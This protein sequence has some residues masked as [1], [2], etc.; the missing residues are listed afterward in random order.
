MND[1]LEA[2]ES[3]NAHDFSYLSQLGGYF[4]VIDSSGKVE[5]I[6][7]SLVQNLQLEQ[8][9]WVGQD[10]FSLVSVRNKPK[11]RKAL[12]LVNGSAASIDMLSF[13]NGAKRYF[14][15]TLARNR[16]G[17]GDLNYIINLHDITKR[18][19]HEK[20][21]TLK[22]KEL[23]SF[24]YKVSHDLK[25]P[26]KSI[27]GLINLS[28]VN[29]CNKDEYLRLINHGISQ[30]QSYIT[31]LGLDVREKN[32]KISQVDLRKFLDELIQELKFTPEAHRITFNIKVRN[33]IPISTDLFLLSTILRN[34]LSNAIKYQDQDRKRP[35]VNID[36][37]T[38]AGLFCVEIQDNGIGISEDQ[39]RNIFTMFHRASNTK[40][41][42]GVG[43]AIANEAAKRIKGTIEVSSTLR[44]G[45]TFRLNAFNYNDL[46][47]TAKV[48]RQSIFDNH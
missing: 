10:L 22:N 1:Q 28:K 16:S 19:E 26:L 42:T 23:D 8:A 30:M 2:K 20:Q 40:E 25:A 11:I 21:L 18:V 15:A 39:L 34:L 29:S 45:S 38:R 24:I 13:K 6:S 47:K 43:L 46:K 35:E 3:I 48:T 41:G 44:K 5:F 12:R 14:D 31:E 36:V 9:N 27:E 37:T 33:E 17:H 4:L 32:L 7:R